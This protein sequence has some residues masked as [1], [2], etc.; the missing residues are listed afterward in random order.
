MILTESFIRQ[1]AREAKTKGIFFSE[2]TKR[3]DS[4][5]RYDLFISHSFDDSEIVFGLYQLFQKAGY[6]VYIDWV[7][8]SNLD[9]QNVNSETASIIKER[10]Q[11]SKGTAYISSS[12]STTS[13]WC[14][15]E[16]GVAD[17]MKGRVCIFPIMISD[18]KGQEYL[19]LYPY[20]EYEKIQGKEEYEFWVCDQKDKNKYVQ[21]RNWL[22]GK[23][24]VNH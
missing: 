9:R 6:S 10:I 8:D 4:E 7:V 16:L 14:P 21:L 22:S 1:S 19:S 5:Q 15:W 12:N 24:P 13:K 2:S 20:L 3:F 23:N 11:A 18:F 17:G